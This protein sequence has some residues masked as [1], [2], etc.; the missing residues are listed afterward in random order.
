MGPNEIERARET[1]NLLKAVLEE[2][3]VVKEYEMQ[4]MAS[5]REIR[6]DL[7]NLDNLRPLRKEKTA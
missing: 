5:Q 3:R 7:R 2:V 6:E 1:V 4:I